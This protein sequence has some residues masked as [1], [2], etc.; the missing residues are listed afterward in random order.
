MKLINHTKQHLKNSVSHYIGTRL[1][2]RSD[3]FAGLGKAPVPTPAIKQ[4]STPIVRH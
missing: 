3:A 4:Q 1:K 2:F